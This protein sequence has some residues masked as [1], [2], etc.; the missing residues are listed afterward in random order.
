MRLVRSLTSA[1]ET[2]LS[3][4]CWLAPGP[5]CPRILLAVLVA[6][7]IVGSLGVACMGSGVR[8]AA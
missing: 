1:A 7:V 2:V 6:E 4:A 8:S 5:R 3:L